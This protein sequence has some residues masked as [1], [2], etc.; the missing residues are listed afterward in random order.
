MSEEEK[1]SRRRDLL[2]RL[3]HH[4]T[5]LTGLSVAESTFLPIPLETLV[6]PL[7]VGHPARATAI[8]LWIWLGALIG[9]AILFALGALAAD[10]LVRPAL[11]ALGF[12]EDFDQMTERLGQEGLFWTV[13]VISVSPAPMQ[14]ATLGAGAAGGNPLT[15]L[16]AIALSRGIRYFGLALLAQFVGERLAHF[17]IPKRVLIPAL[18]ATLLVLWGLWQLF[19]G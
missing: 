19:A 5:G 15:V 10:S 3:A 16:A 1:H 14:I 9:G 18:I 11:A 2:E 17:D 13:F 7:M 6:V 4:K 12:A 8:A